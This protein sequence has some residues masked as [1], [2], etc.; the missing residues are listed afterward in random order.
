[1]YHFMRDIFAKGEVI[2]KYIPMLEVII[3]PLQEMC[4]HKPF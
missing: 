4:L 1:M 2:L 3:D